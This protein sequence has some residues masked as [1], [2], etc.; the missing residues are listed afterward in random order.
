MKKLIAL[1]LAVLLLST[2]AAFAADEIDLTTYTDEELE[3][4]KV[5]IAEEIRSRL[6]TEAPE[7]PAADFRYASNGKE[8]RIISYLGEGGDVYIPDEI[9]GVPVTQIHHSAF[10]QNNTITSVR[11]PSGLVSIGENAFYRC[12]SLKGV[13]VLPKTVKLLDERAFCDTHLTGIVLQSDCK[14]D[15]AALCSDSIEFVY[16]R[17]GTNLNMLSNYILRDNTVTLVLPETVTHMR[18]FADYHPYT[19]LTIYCPADSYAEQYATE[20]F[21]VCNTADY[22]AMVAYYEALYFPE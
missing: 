10:Y 9:D 12:S 16:C 20:N 17:E 2:T 11:L 1:F 18:T 4:L 6:L 21:I 22:E 13:I 15:H 7:S 14:I 8:V 19:Y 5:Q 3:A